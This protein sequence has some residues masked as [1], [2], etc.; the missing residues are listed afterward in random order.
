MASVR[1]YDVLN[2]D[3][4]QVLRTFYDKGMNSSSKDK[5][6]LML[7]AAEETG[8]SFEKVKVLFLS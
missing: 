1:S 6:E 7:K 5:H 3:Q 4:K 2:E 8:I